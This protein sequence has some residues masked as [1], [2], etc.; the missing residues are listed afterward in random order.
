M[1]IKGL[2]SPN[3]AIIP[4][5]MG[6]DCNQI[7]ML[8]TKN[9]ELEQTVES[10]AERIKHLT[11]L[12]YGRK[13]ERFIDPGQLNLFA[14]DAPRLPAPPPEV[15]STNA[16]SKPRR[17]PKRRN[18]EEMAASGQYEVENN[19]LSLPT[20][21]QQCDDCNKDLV[22][23][24]HDVSYM[25]KRTPAQLMIIKNT[26]LK[27]GCKPCEGGVKSA[28]LPL[29]PIPKSMASSSLLA[30]TIVS[31]FCD[32]LPLYRQA[33]MWGRDGFDIN[34][35]TL[36]SWLLKCSQLAQ[37]L[38][39]LMAKTIK[40][41]SMMQIDESYALVLKDPDRGNKKK[42]YM[43]VYK[44]GEPS[45]PSIVFQYHPSRSGKIAKEFLSGFKGYAQTDGYGGYDF[46][47]KELEIYQVFCMAHARR[48]FMDVVKKIKNKPG[49]A[50]EAVSMI[51]ELY[52]IE[53]QAKD[54]STSE[55]FMIR[56]TKAKPIMDKI[57]VWLDNHIMTILPK[58]ETGKAIAYMH[59]RMPG[60]YRYLEHGDIEIDNN[61]IENA[62]RP[63]ALGRKNY[64]FMGSPEGAKAAANFY[65]LLGTCAANNVEPYKY[66]QA[67]L[68]RIRYCK[69]EDDY[70]ALLPQHIV[71]KN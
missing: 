16:V 28:P 33:I 59:K 67:M 36:C 64:L 9:S 22:V 7:A 18:L 62:I 35:S 29:W 1:E 26:R 21:D 23:I 5:I 24:G 34:R 60:L 31:K 8:I 53:R 39:D 40:S 3:P 4:D 17:K 50:H 12:I 48:K 45:K 20:D 46:I 44:G 2:A 13:S 55:R 30:Y 15:E 41:G 11:Q 32:H 70:R 37:P 43:W 56:L 63:L 68:D 10:M 54:M 69:T 49:L 65:S 71:F 66:F 19:M 58:S 52:K 47:E 14:N 51:R 38:V 25:L 6:N 57:K 61:G 27:Y 42:S